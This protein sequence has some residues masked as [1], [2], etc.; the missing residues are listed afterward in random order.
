MRYNEGVKLFWDVLSKRQT[1]IL[2][3][4][5]FL[6]DKNFYLA[7]G[8]ALALQIKHRTS[9]DFDFYIPKEFDAAKIY[10]Q[11][12]EQKPKKILLDTM[13]KDTLLLELN[14]IGISLFTYPYPLL[15]TF[16]E[17]DYLNL[18]SLEDIAA[19]KLIA[20]IQRGIRRDFVDL[21]FL[22]KKIGL[23][24]IFRFTEKK[25]PGFNEYVALQAL[26]YFRDTEIEENKRKINFFVPFKWEEA[27][28]FFV[29]EVNKIKEKWRKK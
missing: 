20:I 25:Y 10:R 7:G 29:S 22:I 5:S 13:A 2:P 26:I 23:E 27:K 16:I 14:D 9:I 11:F 21:Y 17:T 28:K 19:M 18:A 8:T 4:L 3:R 6:K 1:E 15:K 12:Q 24:K